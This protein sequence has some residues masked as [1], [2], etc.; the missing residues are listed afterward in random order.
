M[1]DEGAVLIDGGFVNPDGLAATVV[2]LA[3]GPFTPRDTEIFGVVA[4]EVALRAFGP[5]S[6]PT[7]GAAV[8]V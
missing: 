2:R 3:D 8:N 5:P 4:A 6:P 7:A 1:L